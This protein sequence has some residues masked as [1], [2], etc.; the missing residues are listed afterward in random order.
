MTDLAAAHLRALDACVPGTHRVYNLGNGTGI[1]VRE[2][3]E[4]CRSVTGVD[5]P[6]RVAPRRP[7]DPAVLVASSARIQA[8][9]GWTA[10]LDLRAMVA[11]AWALPR[12]ATLRRTMTAGD[13][14][15]GLPGG[16]AAAHAGAASGAAAGA[17]RWRGA[18]AH[19]AAWFR[20]SYGGDP[21]G[22]W[23]APGRVNLIGEHTDYNEGFVLPFALGSGVRAAAARAGN[24]TRPGTAAGG[25][26]ARSSTA[27]DRAATCS[28]CPHGRPRPSG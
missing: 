22:V 23:H 6:A 21:A 3:I 28:N 16:E 11:D 1:S 24:V 5:I 26:R 2:V 18:V 12:V 13:L 25:D 10:R 20:D 4:M 8:E 9:L 17:S 14:A 27:A 7:G 15:A 19:A